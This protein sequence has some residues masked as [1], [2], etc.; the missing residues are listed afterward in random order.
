MEI[1]EDRE[2]NKDVSEIN[3]TSNV[4]DTDKFIM[5]AKQDNED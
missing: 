2:K 4:G 3:M 5:A 1:L